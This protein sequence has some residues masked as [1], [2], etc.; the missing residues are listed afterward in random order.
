MRRFPSFLSL[1]LLTPA[2][3]ALAVLLADVQGLLE[4]DGRVRNAAWVSLAVALGP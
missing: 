1:P 2:I 3:V 4:I